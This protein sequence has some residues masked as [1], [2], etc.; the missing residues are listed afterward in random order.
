MRVIPNRDWILL[1]GLAVM[2]V[3]VLLVVA[4]GLARVGWP[5]DIR[6]RCIAAPENGRPKPNCMASIKTA[7]GPWVE[8]RYN[9]CGYRATGPCA[10]PPQG[11]ARIAVIGSSTSFGYLVP[12]DHA[13][14]V[15]AGRTITATCKRP[16]DVQSLIPI[17]PDQGGF[18]TNL[19]IIASRLPDAVAL[20]PQMVALV[21]APMDLFN[22]P[23]GDFDPTASKQLSNEPADPPTGLV[24]YTKSLLSGSRAA[25]VLQ[26]YMFR[27][28]K[29]YTAAYLRHGDRADFLRSPLSPQ[30]K[31][32][33]AY[34][35][36]I[37]A[38]LSNQ[39]KPAGVP[40]LLVYAPQQAQ[41][42]II[43]DAMELPGVEAE[44]LDRAISGIAEHHGV[45]FADGADAFR[46][47]KDVPDF[48]YQAD[49]HLNA[50]GQTLLGHTAAA[51]VF[52]AQPDG[53]CQR[54]RQVTR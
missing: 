13:W 52:A 2:T 28:E 1:P 41:A 29:T 9:E 20:H 4:E 34:L 47:V 12:F 35:D 45:I 25:T 15:E 37:V 26:H 40:L 5:E 11:T 14:S 19:G 50:E 6:D 38:Y 44:T 21:V 39:L 8:A 46:G 32:R 36:S 49:G 42:Y 7:E 51:A 16:I 22:L 24:E 54:Q 31:Q 43:A 10:P 53:F 48:F 18:E 23:E 3:V 17:T 27:N 33:L 30:W